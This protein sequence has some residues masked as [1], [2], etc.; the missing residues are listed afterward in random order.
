M[1]ILIVEDDPRIGRNLCDFL[2]AGGHQCTLAGT[3]AEGQQSIDR[4][5]PD[6]LV[7]DLNLPDGD[8]LEFAR[9]LRSQGRSL[10]VLMLT[11]RDT[12]DDKLSGFGAGADDY[13]VKPFALREVE[14]RLQALVRRATQGQESG[15]W[16]RGPLEYNAPQQEVQLDGVPLRLAPKALGLLALFLQSPDRLFTRG[17]IELAVWGHEQGSSDSLRSLLRVVRHELASSD[18]VAIENLHGQGYRLVIR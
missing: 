4:S 15:V 14:V 8:G 13:L 2:E 11:A 9:G 3:L 5:P 17:E 6:A 1:R 7:L 16:R 12:L 10:P 18:Q